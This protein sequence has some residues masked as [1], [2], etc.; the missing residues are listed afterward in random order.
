MLR[1]QGRPSG[2]WLLGAALRDVVGAALA[3]RRVPDVA[4]RFAEALPIEVQRARSERLDQVGLVVQDART[5][6]NEATGDGLAHGRV[7][8]REQDVGVPEV[9]QELRD[10]DRLGPEGDGQRHELV[11]LVHDFRDVF[12]LVDALHH[13]IAANDAQVPGLQGDEGFLHLRV[14]HIRNQEAE[15]SLDDDQRRPLVHGARLR[16]RPLCRHLV[17]D[18]PFL[19]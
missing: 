7:V 15:G 17:H 8:L 16:L 12:G 6:V 9:V 14:L 18:E 1:V 5:V 3:E 10:G 4:V 11:V 19:L 2:V 13:R